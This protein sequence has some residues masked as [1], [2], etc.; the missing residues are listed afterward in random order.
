MRLLSLLAVVALVAVAGCSGRAQV[1]GKVAFSDGT[2]LDCGV[3]NFANDTTI[4]KGEINKKGEY[5]MRTFKPGDGVPKGSYKVYITETLKFGESAGTMMT[6]DVETQLLG[7]TTNILDPKYSNPDESGLTITVQGSQKYD[8]TLEGLP[9]E[10]DE[11][12]E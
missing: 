8:I 1:T 9:P 11:S 10:S 12:A 7:T 5:T 6:G 3:V 2:P 4:C